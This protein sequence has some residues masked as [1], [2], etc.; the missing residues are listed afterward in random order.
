MFKF[1][2]EPQMKTII[3]VVGVGGAGNNAVNRMIATGLEG[4]DYIVVNTDSQQL[5]ASLAQT[6]IQIG[7]KLTRGLGAGADPSIGREAALED[8]DKLEKGLKGAD[9]VFI[10]AGMG[11]GTGT[12]A[13]PIVAEVAKES[14]ALVVGV[15]TKPFRAEGRRRMQHADEGIK[16][17]K[18]K[19]DTII[20]IPNDLLLKI[21]DRSTPMD[22]AFKLADDI[23]R[24]G[25]QG[26]ADIIMVT[27]LVNVDFA[28][29]RTVMK[30]TGD[31]IMGVG[32][33]VG[34]NR[35]IEATQMA[36]NSPLLEESGIEGAKAVL[37]NI[38]GGS[39][40][41]LHEVNEITE[42]INKQVDPDAN[43]IFGATI[44]PALDDKIRVTVIATGFDRKLNMLNRP[45]E[46]DRATGTPLTVIEGK[47]HKERIEKKVPAQMKSF[48]LDY[49]KRRVKD[50]SHE[51]LDIPAFLRRNAE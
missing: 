7:T 44:D 16:N 20:V 10:T 48:T 26:I 40:M 6:K 28:D 14:G 15:V 12:G 51:D 50:Y 1:D 35:A 13:A 17:L 18:E 39:D 43:I 5:K 2:E 22:H 25:V 24:Q 47:N 3:K 27:G 8:R 31:A 41:S 21:I 45:N 32:I 34:E 11:G 42:I 4:V 23:L 29:V 33:G 19:V 36:I 49:E 38:A 9:M 37:L 46:L 30:E